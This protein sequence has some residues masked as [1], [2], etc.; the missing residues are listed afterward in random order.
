MSE[1]T[2]ERP[3]RGLPN[4]A[5]LVA[6][7]RALEERVTQIEIRAQVPVIA[8]ANAKADPRGY[9]ECGS[10]LPMHFDHCPHHPSNTEGSRDG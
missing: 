3:A 9:C 8:V 1:Q 10:R 5:Q 6:E 2:A 7:L 4:H